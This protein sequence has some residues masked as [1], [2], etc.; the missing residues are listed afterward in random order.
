MSKPS[1]TPILVTGSHRSGTTWVGH[2]LCVSGDA[3]Y[4]HE[5]FSLSYVPGWG[6][7]RFPHWFQYV[8]R[9]NEADFVRAI[10]DVL[11]FQYPLRSQL[12]EVRRP[13]S[14]ARLVRDWVH[15]ARHRATG[16]R[17][18][19]KDPIAVFSTE[20]LASRFDA[21]PV[22]M[23]RHPAGFVGSVL[24]LG[25]TFDFGQWTSQ[26]LLMR[27][28][29]AGYEAQI[30]EYAI[31][32]AAPIDQ[33]IL[34]WNAIYGVVAD[35]QAAHADWIF[36]RH[37]DLAVDP[38]A[39][40]EHLYAG[41]GLRWDDATRARIQDYSSSQAGSMHLSWNE[42]AIVKRQ[43]KGVIKTWQQRLTRAEVAKVRAAVEPTSSRFYG[44]EDWD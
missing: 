42:P 32:P 1:L 36:V 38:S 15:A 29:L 23:I 44:D 37:E 14:A 9:E 41:L 39:G 31:V 12:R 28:L 40:F 6:A 35:F 19:M 33:A 5:P 24:E 22:V 17:P 34:L 8:C 16:V 21:R 3:G 30:N 13:K 7:G 11:A 25:F 10:E 18:L 2:M 43:S 4:I 20:W 27:D 26:P